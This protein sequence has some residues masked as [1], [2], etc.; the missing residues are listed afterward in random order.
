MGRKPPG[1]CEAFLAEAFAESLEK[2]TLNPKGAVSPSTF[3]SEVSPLPAA[4]DLL[5]STATLQTSVPCLL[6]I[7]VSH[8]KE[9]NPLAI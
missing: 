3:F 2:H 8:V 6:V 4:R 5:V 9:K 1:V 7:D